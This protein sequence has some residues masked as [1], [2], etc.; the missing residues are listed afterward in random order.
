MRKMLSRSHWAV[1]AALLAAA[2]GG[3][4]AFAAFPQSDV[5]TYT[6]CV[7]TGG[8]AGGQVSGLAEGN[9]PAKPCS[10]NQQVIHLGGGDITEVSAGPGLT[11]GGTNGAV[12]LGLDA[13]HSLPQECSPG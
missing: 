4:A 7:G 1:A 8:N 2:A 10:P 13:G 11:G 3:S 9:E 6:G 12:T 5:A